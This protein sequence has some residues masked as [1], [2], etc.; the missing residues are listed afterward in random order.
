MRTRA[1]MLAATLL[2]LYGCN[3]FGN[4]ENAPDRFVNNGNGTV[5][6]RQTGLVWLRSA[7][8]VPP[9][10][11]NAAL[12]AAAE[13][14]AGKCGLTDGSVAGD[15][16]VPTKDEWITIVRASCYP[17]PGGPTIP[18]TSGSGCFAAGEQWAT[19]VQPRFYWS[20]TPDDSD[21]NAAWAV[22]LYSGYFDPDSIIDTPFV[23]P[24][25]N[26]R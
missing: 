3:L 20:S 25:R 7:G 10:S 5:T 22:Q 11:W 2:L 12:A 8:C 19:G 21:P 13:L 24:V 9:Q 1:H 18:N 17:H 15:W 26:R 6:D 14:S 16:R 23:W 4:S